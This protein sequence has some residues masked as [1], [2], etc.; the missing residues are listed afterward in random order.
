MRFYVRGDVD[1]DEYLKPGLNPY[2]K[3]MKCF[4]CGRLLQVRDVP[5]HIKIFHYD[6]H[7]NFIDDT[8]TAEQNQILNDIYNNKDDFA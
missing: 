5:K 7:G 3:F 6:N 1:I 8:L 2:D 4:Y